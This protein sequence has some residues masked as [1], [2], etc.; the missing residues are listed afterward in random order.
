MESRQR[1]RW[2]D[3]LDEDTVNQIRDSQAGVYTIL[4]WLEV[5]GVEGATKNKVERLMR[6][7]RNG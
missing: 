7:L 4:R 2:S 6:E 1:P 5:T 3:G